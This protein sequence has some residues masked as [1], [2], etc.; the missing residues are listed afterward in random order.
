MHTIKH[1]ITRT[2]EEEIELKHRW[3]VGDR[4]RDER[5][6]RR[7]PFTYEVKSVEVGEHPTR[8]PMVKYRYTD[9]GWDWACVD[10]LYVDALPRPDYSMKGR[11]AAVDKLTDVQ[12]RAIVLDLIAC[13]QMDAHPKDPYQMHVHSGGRE[14]PVRWASVKPVLRQLNIS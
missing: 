7:R 14:V 2:V 6:P 11:H 4:I 5:I 3:T 12:M 8:G 9:G 13:I 1:T 10:E